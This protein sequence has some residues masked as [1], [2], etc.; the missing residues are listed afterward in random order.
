MQTINAQFTTL[1]T[2]STVT[3]S[4]IE[5][6]LPVTSKA[7]TITC[8]HKPDCC[9]VAGS[10]SK[11]AFNVL[12]VQVGCDTIIHATTKLQLHR[13]PRTAR[14]QY[15]LAHLPTSA[16]DCNEWLAAISADPLIHFQAVAV[17]R[18]YQILLVAEYISIIAEP[19]RSLPASTANAV[20]IA[21]DTYIKPT[22]FDL[23][24]RC[25]SKIRL[26]AMQRG[27]T[28]LA[29]AMSAAMNHS[30]FL[31]YLAYCNTLLTSEVAA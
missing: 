10:S 17:W 6:D 13:M 20:Q 1:A 18:D 31:P 12:R 21:L 2:G 16:P 26:L 22:S 7:I 15:Q 19:V 24:V 28:T 4:K 9:T 30:D 8:H 5:S 25:K 27:G 3:I 29:N 11:E 14:Y 23:G